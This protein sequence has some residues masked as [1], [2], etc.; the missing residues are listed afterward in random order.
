MASDLQKRSEAMNN[1]TRKAKT[2][3]CDVCGQ[4]A[5]SGSLM[6]G[7]GF[8]CSEDCSQIAHGRV[9]SYHEELT[10]EPLGQMPDNME[11]ADFERWALKLA[12]HMVKGMDEKIRQ[13]IQANNP[14]MLVPENLSLELKDQIIRQIPKCYVSEVE[15]RGHERIFH[16]GTYCFRQP[17]PKDVIYKACQKAQVLQ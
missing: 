11:T 13:K 17:V 12:L 2:M 8:T 7:F 3:K 4:E 5:S 16:G 15:A 9:K 6:F 1:E 10:A 14:M